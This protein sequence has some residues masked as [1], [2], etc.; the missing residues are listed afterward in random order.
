MV[1]KSAVMA[2]RA[3]LRRA[4]CCLALVFI[5]VF[6]LMPMQA[7]AYYNRGSVTVDLGT[8]AVEVKAGAT[9]SVTVSISP[10][11]DEQ[12]EGCG[13]PLCPQ[14]CSPSCADENGQCT[15]A[16]KEY[17]TYYPT[18]VARSSNASVA[19]ATYKAGTL[20][21]YGK[22][23]GEATITVRASLRQ[24]TD[25]EE[26]LQV[27]VSGEAAG[28]QKGS[29]A[30]ADIPDAADAVEDDRLDLIEKTVMGRPIHN[31]RINERCDVEARLSA[32]AG[33]DGDVIFW[34]GDTYYQPNYSL[35]FKGTN[36]GKDN[37]RPLDVTLNVTS[38]A[39]GAMNQ[40]LSGLDKF[41]VIDFAQKGKL[42]APVEV[43]AYTQGALA[44][45]DE[46][47]LYSYDEGSKSFTR[48]DVD[49]DVRGGYA[50]YTVDEGKTYVVSTHDLTTEANAVVSGAQGGDVAMQST[51]PLAGVLLA[52]VAV[53]VIAAIVIV[54]VLRKNKKNG[55]EEETDGD[56]S[57]KSDE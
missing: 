48:E 37:V 49:V 13:M 39:E 45:D 7:F 40:P 6:S 25:A 2:N 14:G 16:G 56:I 30:F 5:L 22:K 34:E 4:V 18:A 3:P 21:V 9:A 17:K 12:T 42:F 46:V 41:L 19:V 10:S 32:M 23:E 55:R 38:K 35:T 33:I 36:Y 50:W 15:C 28:Y 26:T 24:F 27:K 11:S 8:T 20:T 44:D 43:Y 54:V 47:A 57:D 1:S 51:A 52:V 53:V 31:V 29:D